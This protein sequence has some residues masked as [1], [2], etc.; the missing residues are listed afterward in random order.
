MPRARPIM[1]PRL[2]SSLEALWVL[3]GSAADWSFVMM[4]VTVENSAIFARCDGLV[5]Q[6]LVGSCDVTETAEE[7]SAVAPAIRSVERNVS[8]RQLVLTSRHLFVCSLT[9]CVKK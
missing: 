3:T 2:E 6:G 7:V 4:A 9:C 8:A 1:T 5:G